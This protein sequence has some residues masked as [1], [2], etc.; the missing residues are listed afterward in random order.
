MIKYYFS[1]GS[2]L[3]WTRMRKR[4]PN[5]RPLGAAKINNMRLIFRSFADIEPNYSCIVVGGLWRIT[6]SC[7]QA[8][9]R[10]EEIENGLYRKDYL[11]LRV[12]LEG[13]EQEILPL[14]YM[15][16]SKTYAQ[17]S[18]DYLSIIRE[19]YCDFGLDPSILRQALDDTTAEGAA[20]IS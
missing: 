3:S 10:Y 4:C 14:V 17:P 12:I 9:D 2:N 13:Q 8:L 18:E 16:N 20:K 5:A 19:G 6:P 11:P 1:Y 7:E 15:M